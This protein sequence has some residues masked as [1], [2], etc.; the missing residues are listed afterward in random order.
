MR[1]CIMRLIDFNRLEEIE[2]LNKFFLD[3]QDLLFYV[4]A[5]NKREEASYAS[6]YKFDKKVVEDLR[7]KTIL[8]VNKAK[9]ILFQ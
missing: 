3:Y 9:T 4:Q 2:L 5:K 1:L 7:L 8:F 6:V